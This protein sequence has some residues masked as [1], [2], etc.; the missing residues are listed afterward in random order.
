M[1]NQCLLRRQ[2]V[3]LGEK[4]TG[5]KT[6]MQT[7]KRD[8]PTTAVLD[9]ATAVHALVIVAG[10]WGMTVGEAELN[11]ALGQKSVLR[12][13]DFK[14][15]AKVCR[16]KA[17]VTFPGQLAV[18]QLPVPSIAIMQNGTCCVIGQSNATHIMVYDFRQQEPRAEPLPQ[19]MSRWSGRAVVLK[20]PFSF[21]EAGAR[22]NL[23]WFIP[24]VL[25]YKRFLGEIVLASF[26]LQLFGLITPLF[27][28]VI[29]DKVLL[30]KGVATLDVL[31]LALLAAAL[32]QAIMTLL[33]TYLSTHMSNKIDIILGARVFRHLL[34]LPLRYFELRRVGDTL[35]RLSALQSVREFLTGSSPT[36]V[37]DTLFSIVFV[38][39]MLHYSVSLTLLALAAI[40][41]YLLQNVLATP[42]YRQRLE[43]VWSSGAES[44]AFL[45]EA[46]T[47]V[48]T[49]KALALEPQF[50]DR[51]E[52][53][54][55]KYVRTVFQ[56]A[57]FNMVLNGSGSVVQNMAGLVVLLFGGHKVMQGEMTVGELIAFQMLANQAS[58]PLY[59]LTGLW[60]VFQ[61]AF[62]SVERL[63]DILNTPP[64][65]VWANQPAAL[66]AVCGGIVLEDVVFRYQAAGKKVL[67]GV[68]LTIRP[69]MRLGIVG[70]SGSGKSTVAKLIQRLY[71]P[72]SGRVCIG[73]TDV[74]QLDPTWLRRQIGV[75]LQESFLFTGSV[76]ENI[77]W[78]CPGAPV[79]QVIAAAQRAGAHDFI[80]ELPE[81]YDTR[82]GERGAALSGGQRQ[83]IAIARALI[84]EPPVLIF[85]E[86]TSALDYESER[87]IT[88]NLAQIAAGR[89]LILIAHR[90][91][92]IRQCEA[93]LVMEQGKAVEMGS[94]EELMGK[95]GM[96]YR[97]YRQQ[98]SGKQYE[99]KKIDGK[100]V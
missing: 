3:E 70:R 91:S 65:Q 39:V 57:R 45:V 98:E 41:L 61:Q 46:V 22:F 1:N 96:Y 59:R 23:A 80:L 54:M 71:L 6:D 93:I 60:Q 73:G 51:W 49:I 37:L 87:I 40:P 47:G 82:V 27:T 10:T 19:F 36:V 69:G 94:H 56:S 13:S 66:P 53:L 30:H 48:Q 83:R 25:R 35:A 95:Q 76:R 24:V 90:F 15:M 85:D 78:S 74:R 63:G 92:T 32:F 31:A 86:A 100:M 72:E 33:R 12:E 79:E 38:L 97:L 55:A 34:S 67:D 62:L 43:A 42:V 7:I 26:C 89:T 2:A 28:Q 17:K 4:R 21:K 68:N 11:K 14:Q 9:K 64:E 20:R 16:L 75:V 77:A 81:G 84:T 18:N 99:N 8:Q 5:D 52:S 50:N 58:Q 29:V 88:D 44:N